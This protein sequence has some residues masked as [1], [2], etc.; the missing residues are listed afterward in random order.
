MGPLANE[1]LHKEECIQGV[2]Y[3]MSPSPHHRHSEII[4][5]I[6]HILRSHLKTSLCRV[7]ADNIDVYF[8]KGS[9][10]YVI[11]DLSLICDPSK[12]KGGSY[13]GVPK[14][15]VEVLS[16]ST[17][18]KD[19]TIKK[20]LYEAKGVAEYW[21]VDYG[22]NSIDIY[23]LIEG[24]YQLVNAYTL[25]M[26]EELPEYNVGTEIQLKEFPNVTVKLEEIFE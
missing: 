1:E 12:F 13:Y 24:K 18:L 25:V 5:N 26:D 20:E 3:N 14:F 19:L 22:S 21:I 11:P 6:N 17:R 16:P 4:S 23:H 8:E 9:K 15:I 7:Y 2:L 10:D